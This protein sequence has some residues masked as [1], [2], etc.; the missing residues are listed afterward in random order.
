MTGE[1]READWERH[2]QDIRW[3]LKL[4]RPA[5]IQKATRKNIIQGAFHPLVTMDYHMT[6][7]VTT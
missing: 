7:H 4:T 1:T 2:H 3:I 6:C 5:T